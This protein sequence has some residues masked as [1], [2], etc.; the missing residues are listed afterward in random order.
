MGGGASLARSGPNVGS[1]HQ[2]MWGLRTK[3]LPLLPRKNGCLA[4]D[5]PFTER[6]EPRKIGGQWQR[7]G[8][9]ENKVALLALIPKLQLPIGGIL[10][11]YR[12]TPLMQICMFSHFV[13]LD[14]I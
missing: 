9:L 5:K 6:P 14:S 3:H 12:W 8:K 10:F 1:T 13:S 4:T 2:Q 11:D 7:T